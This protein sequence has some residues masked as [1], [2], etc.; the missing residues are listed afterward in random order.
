MKNNKTRLVIFDSV[1]NRGIKNFLL[2]NIRDLITYRFVLY[3]LVNTNL[4]ARY[5]RSAIGFLWTLIN[6][7]FTM[8]ILAVVFSTIYK[9]PFAD[10]GIYIFSGLLPW[11]LISNSILNGSMS[12]ITAEGYLKKVY[13]P[14]L[15]F[16]IATVGVEAANFLFSLTSL[17]VLALILG[18]RASWGLLFLP[19]A[20]LLMLLFVLGVILTVCIITVYFRDMFHI[21]QIV[22][23]GLFYLVPIVYKKEFFRGGLLIVLQLNPFF[24][25]IQLF[26]QIIYEARIPE[27]SLWLVCS[28]LTGVSL[29]IGLLVF[30]SK[31]K[32]IIY[33]L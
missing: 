10:F 14:R 3:N 6:P 19:V 27:L 5:R 18:A 17:F 2:R 31:E 7:L 22:F 26:Q 16:P 29:I 23:V 8:T 13:V 33:R 30:K 28:I 1:E 20:L 32:D 11:S 15:I 9:L 25:F 24:Y 12:L 21:L 4:R